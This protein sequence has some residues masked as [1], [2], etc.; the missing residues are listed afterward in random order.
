MAKIVEHDPFLQKAS[1]AERAGSAV[2][3]ARRLARSVA[4]WSVQECQDVARSSPRPPDGSVGD[5]RILS[6]L[7]PLATAGQAEASSGEPT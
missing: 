4:F 1:S 7:T 2:R 6:T 3:A 5:P